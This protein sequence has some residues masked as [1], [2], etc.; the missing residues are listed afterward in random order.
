[1]EFDDFG[2]P[3]PVRRSLKTKILDK[4]PLYAKILVTAVIVLASVV[5]MLISLGIITPFEDD[6]IEED[7]D[8]KIVGDF[9]EILQLKLDDFFTL[10]S[11]EA[12][13]SVEGVVPNPGWVKITVENFTHYPEYKQHALQLK[14]VKIY[15]K[16]EFSVDRGNFREEIILPLSFTWKKTIDYP[17]HSDSV[18]IS[19]LGNMFF[20]AEYYDSTKQVSEIF[21]LQPYVRASY[22]TP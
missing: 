13:L 17:A 11:V 4:I 14:E 5:T 2:E 1:M 8:T 9:T 21:Y 3:I 16:I 20:K 15:K 6:P 22:F 10:T 19:T 12:I 7:F 18:T